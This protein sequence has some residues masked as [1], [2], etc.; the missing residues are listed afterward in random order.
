MLR[1]PGCLGRWWARPKWGMGSPLPHRKQWDPTR[2]PHL[3]GTGTCSSG[4]R[5]SQEA[6]PVPSLGTESS[7]PARGTLWGGRTRQTRA[8]ELPR[9]HT[10]RPP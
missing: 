5:G 8:L 2:W 4:E 1:N 7:H 6:A 9:A 3:L 10:P